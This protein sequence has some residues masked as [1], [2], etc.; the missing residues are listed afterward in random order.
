MIDTHIHLDSKDFSNDLAL[1]LDRAKKNNVE[2]F[3]IP[4]A[5][6]HTL[7]DAQQIANTYDNV[8]YAVGIHPCH[9]DEMYLD[10]ANKTPNAHVLETLQ[11]YIKSS[12]CK[13]IGECGLDFYHIEKDDTQ[14]IDMQIEVF[15]MQIEWAIKYDLP[16][17]L[18]VRDS[19][20]DYKASMEVAKILSHYIKTGNKI[21]GVFHCYNACEVLL[22]FSEYF[23]YGIGGIITFKNAHDLLSVTPKIPLSKI[24]LETDAPYL[25]PTPHRG[26]RNESSFLIHV[27]NKLSEILNLTTNEIINLT[28]NNAK[29]LFGI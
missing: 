10:L 4:A 1:V 27:A 22:D 7:N 23:Y 12:K 29:N 13:A 25:A 9:A 5:S 14:A 26:K 11:E 2:S 15:N 18:H 28:T 8:Y 19:K 6:T 20:D 17:I 24:V 21:R 3:I 16:L